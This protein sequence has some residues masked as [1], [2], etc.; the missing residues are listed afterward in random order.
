MQTQ[1]VKLIEKIRN[2]SQTNPLFRGE[3]LVASAVNAISDRAAM[4]VV[5]KD[6][7]TAC[8]DNIKPL[9][10]YMD[11]MANATHAIAGYQDVMLRQ[12]M[13]FS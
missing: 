3:R 7:S 6:A 5:V 8:F 10:D 13:L 1:A 11:E 4:G 9:S 2:V 12:V